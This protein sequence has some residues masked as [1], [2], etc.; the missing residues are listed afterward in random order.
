[1]AFEEIEAM[2]GTRD[3]AAKATAALTVA[4]GALV[5]F[6]T[7]SSTLAGSPRAAVA[8]AAPSATGTGTPAPAAKPVRS[9]PSAIDR[10]E[11]SISE[12]H[13][14]L[15]IT[16][17]QEP[18]F[19]AYADVMRSNAVAM[20][21]LFEE[22]A[23][24]TGPSATDTAANRLHW[25]ARLTAAHAEAVNKLVPVFDALY[26]SLSD[27]QKKIADAVFQKNLQQRRSPRRVKQSG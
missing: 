14:T 12:M 25:Y 23:K 5:L 21:A 17:D 13:K 22:R 8:Q 24:S 19:K 16:A 26:Q 3:R 27:K 10:V 7:P 1:L 9:P 15:Q 18:Q 2:I 11:A 6:A 20:Q 4:L